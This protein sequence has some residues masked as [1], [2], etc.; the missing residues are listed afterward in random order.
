MRL[1]VLLTRYFKRYGFKGIMNRSKAIFFDR[2]GIVNFRIVG[3]YVDRADKL[4]IIDDFVLFF[5][6]IKSLG[7]L[8]FLITNQQGI[9]KGLMTENDLNTV[10]E[11]MQNYL[12]SETNHIFDDIFFC[13]HMAEEN[14]L[15]RKPQPGMLL[16]AAEKWNIDLKNSWM[17]GDRK[18]DIEAGKSAGTNTVLIGCKAAKNSTGADFAFVNFFEAMQLFTDEIIK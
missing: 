1:A 17:I 6:R 13:P 16:E 18:S 4:K 3:E 14:C 5:R 2:D 12:I 9:G 10:H 7:Y 15:C 11:E 8:T